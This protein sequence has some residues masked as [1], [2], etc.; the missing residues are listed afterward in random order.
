MK[1][2]EKYLVQ[3]RARYANDAVHRAKVRED[4]QA[5]QQRYKELQKTSPKVN[6]S[7]MATQAKQREGGDISTEFLLNMWIEQDGKCALTGL[8]MVWG[9]GVVSAMNVSIDRIDQSRG[10]FQDN[11]R[12]V[13][14]CANS[15]RQQMSDEK[16]LAV[17]IAMVNTLK[18]KIGS[19]ELIAKVTS[20]PLSFKA[21]V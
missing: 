11:V 1:T 9:Q 21:Y 7:R 13:C 5:V 16:L 18:S 3:R 15:F 20:N 2:K 17:A 4:N 8:Q 19:D 6:L 12:L 14:W 10:Y